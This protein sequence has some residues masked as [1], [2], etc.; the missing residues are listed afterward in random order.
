MNLILYKDES[1]PHI[2][3]FFEFYAITNVTINWICKLLENNN[4]TLSDK[5]MY[6]MSK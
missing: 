6:N 3:A 4:Y 2:N 1:I 5:K